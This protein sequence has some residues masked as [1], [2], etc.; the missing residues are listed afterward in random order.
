MNVDFKLERGLP[1]RAR[2]VHLAMAPTHSREL[3]RLS[4]NQRADASL[5][6]AGSNQRLRWDLAALYDA[7]NA[8]RQ[9]QV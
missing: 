6:V 4:A 2:A 3:P 7:L 8:R 9:E 1:K 5:P